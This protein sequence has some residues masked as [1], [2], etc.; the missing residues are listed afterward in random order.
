MKRAEQLLL[1]KLNRNSGAIMRTTCLKRPQ[2][3]ASC[4]LRESRGFPNIPQTKPST[5]QVP[6]QK[7]AQPTKQILPHHF[8]VLES[9]DIEGSVGYTLSLIRSKGTTNRSK[10]RASEDSS[11]DSLVE[12]ECGPVVMYYPRSK[13]KWPSAWSD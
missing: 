8:P 12:T 5:Q 11:E 6:N 13:I 2:L 10:E 7:P 3:W 1:A 4:S 9:T